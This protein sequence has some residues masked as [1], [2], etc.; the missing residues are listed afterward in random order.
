MAFWLALIALACTSDTEPGT[1]DT[2]TT[3][4]GRDSGITDTE[5]TQDTEDTSPPCEVAVLATE[6]DTDDDDHFWRDPLRVWFDDAF[7]EGTSPTFTLSAVADGAAL[8]LTETWDEA[9]LSVE[10]AAAPLAPSTGHEL[11]IDACD[12]S[13]SVLFSTSVYGEPVTDG[14]E[15]LLDRSWVVPLA[16]VPWTKPESAA[17]LLTVVLTEPL[18]IGV[19]GVDGD[20]LHM[21]AAVGRHAGWGYFDYR[22][23]GEGFDQG[24]QSVPTN[25]GISSDRK[26]GFFGLLAE[27]TGMGG[28]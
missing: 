26:R 5:D 8:P 14:P 24:Y 4:T 28:A 22:M 25:W 18:L 12:Q 10:L 23:A 16:E 15:S 11:T 6:P 3:E 2:G 20:Q 9:G 19:Y 13:W 1:T 27:V 7:P 21:L 17:D